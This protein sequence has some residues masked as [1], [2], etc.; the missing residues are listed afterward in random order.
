MMNKLPISL[1]LCF[2]FVI[3]IF[4]VNTVLGAQSIDALVEQG[5]LSIS[6]NVIQDEQQIVGQALVISIEVAT[7]RW[8]STGSRVQNFTMPN[9]VMQANNI[10]TINGTKRIKGQTWAMQT[11]EITLYPTLAGSYKL[12]S[13]NVDVSVNT[14]NDGIISG[15]LSTQEASFTIVL[16]EQLVGIANFIV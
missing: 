2:V 3:N 9:V 4:C 16:P 11:H 10:V 7:D 15:L 13:L 8:F 14:E 1:L 5:K 12:P 6:V